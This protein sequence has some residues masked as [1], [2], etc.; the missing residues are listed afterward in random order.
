MVLIGFLDI[1]KTN[2]V[3][4]AQAISDSIKKVIRNSKQQA[5]DEKK[6]MYYSV[7]ILPNHSS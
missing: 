2:S 5:G 4:T 3:N 7:A 1:R 6:T